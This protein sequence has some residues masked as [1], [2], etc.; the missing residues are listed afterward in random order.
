[1]KLPNIPR[2]EKIILEIL[3]VHQ[4]EVPMAN[5]LAFL[6]N[7]KEKHKL[8]SL[9]IDSLLETDCYELDKNKPKNG[10]L[11]KYGYV[12]DGDTFKVST[13]MNDKYS[14]A[15]SSESKIKVEKSESR[16]RIDL[17]IT[18][19]KEKFAII[20]EFKINHHLNNPLEIYRKSVE[21]EKYKDYQLF[22]V[23]LTPNK[24]DAGSM[25]IKIDQFKQIVLSDFIQTIKA[26]LSYVDF[27]ELNKTNPYFQYFLQFI[28]TIE[29][30]KKNHE[31][32]ELV[33]KYKLTPEVLHKD[34]DLYEKWNAELDKINK[35]IF[36]K[37]TRLK[38]KLKQN[39]YPVYP[40]IKS[41]KNTEFP[42]GIPF[43]NYVMMDISDFTFK[44]RLT[45]TGWAIEK[46]QKLSGEK[47]DEANFDFTTSTDKILQE[48]K[49]LELTSNFPT[50][51]PSQN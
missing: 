25:N 18:N 28:N 1:M 13:Q 39:N 43:N 33:L 42:A 14:L 10:Q 3:K 37:L 35:E 9:F 47:T 11:N 23:V 24:K 16:K 15:N 38:R 48:V 12:L 2:T 22:F 44:I 29:N 30:R 20:I 41:G 21:K 19:D 46:W 51:D 50:V 40:L 5:L 49:L 27:I 17:F 6:F 36:Q 31:I 4:R 7:P 32:R 34:D 45:L 8:G 26:K